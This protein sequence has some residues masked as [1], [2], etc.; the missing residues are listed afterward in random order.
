MKDKL[1]EIIKNYGVNNQLRKLNEEVFELQESIIERQNKS[2]SLEGKTPEIVEP[3]IKEYIMNIAQEIADCYVM[4]E[5][6][7][8]YYNISKE[9]IEDI[10]KYKVERQLSRI[11]K[12]KE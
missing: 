3:V 8:L 1:L 10:M 11:A 5:Q 6:F 7:R 2:W 12:E 9:K 4:I